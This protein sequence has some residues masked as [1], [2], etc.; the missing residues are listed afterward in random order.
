ME[1]QAVTEALTRLITKE[2]TQFHVIVYSDSKYVVD[3]ITKWVK[4]WKRNGWK[5]K[6]GG[7][8]KNQ[9]LWKRIDTLSSSFPDIQFQWVKG[10]SIHEGNIKADALAN[11]GMENI[12]T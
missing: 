1:M 11:Q 9:D 3:G 4:N 5:L 7:V 2:Y 8:V 12:S 6:N 10:H